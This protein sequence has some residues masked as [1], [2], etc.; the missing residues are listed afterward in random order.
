M[1]VIVGEMKGEKIMANI[2]ISLL[3]TRVKSWQV[4]TKAD[5]NIYQLYD[6]ILVPEGLQSCGEKI[7]E[8]LNQTIKAILLVTQQDSLI[9][10]NSITHQAISARMPFITPLHVLQV[11]Y[12]SKFRQMMSEWESN[13]NEKSETPAALGLTSHVLMVTIQGIAAGMQN[14][15]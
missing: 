5:Q 2:S 7:R 8:E 12:L 1:I 15:G 4:L 9:E 13:L 10:K 14:T 11:H 6:K 3:K